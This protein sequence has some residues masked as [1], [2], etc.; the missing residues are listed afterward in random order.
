[1]TLSNRMW[2]APQAI[3]PHGLTGIGCADGSNCVAV[4]DAGNAVVLR[5]GSWA[6]P[7]SVDATGLMAVACTSGGA[8]VATDRL[9]SVVS[10]A[11]KT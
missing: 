6:A 4:D 8:C 2:S 7:R 9:G 10:I 3:D 1:M 5:L 11:V